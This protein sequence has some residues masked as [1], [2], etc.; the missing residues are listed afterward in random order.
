MNE[1]NAIIRNPA[2]QPY[3]AIVKG[4]RNG[5]VYGAKIRAPVEERR[6]R[7]RAD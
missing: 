2:L 3:L 1:I 4:A 6:Q 5:L 7:R